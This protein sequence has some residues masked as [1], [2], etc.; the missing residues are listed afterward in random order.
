MS[1]SEPSIVA[2]VSTRRS[3][4]GIEAKQSDRIRV[5]RSLEQRVDRGMLDDFASIHDRDFVADLRN[6]P[7]IVR[8]QDNRG[9]RLSS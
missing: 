4:R 1:G 7:E 9:V 3:S 8:D 6:H 2:S 5:L